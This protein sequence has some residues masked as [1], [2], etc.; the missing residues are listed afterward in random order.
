MPPY[1]I[2]FSHVDCSPTN[3]VTMPSVTTTWKQATTP[4]PCARD[5]R[6]RGIQAGEFCV[7]LD[8]GRTVH[9]VGFCRD[10]HGNRLPN[11]P[12]EEDKTRL[13]PPY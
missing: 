11:F 2:V 10:H 13:G 9:A 1:K 4:L 6:C 12:W 7:E 8:N 3:R 5:P